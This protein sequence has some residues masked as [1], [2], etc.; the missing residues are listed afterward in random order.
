[1]DAE[2]RDVLRTLAFIAIAVFVGL[3]YFNGWGG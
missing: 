1:V 2:S 3:A